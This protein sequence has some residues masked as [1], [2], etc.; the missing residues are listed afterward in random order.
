MFLPLVSTLA[1]RFGRIP[2]RE[3]QRLLD[4]MQSYMNSLNESAAM[5]MD[6]TPSRE[7]PTSPEDG[8]SKEAIGAISRAYR[9]IFTSRNNSSQERPAKRANIPTNSNTPHFSQDAHF[10]Q[11]SSQPTSTQSYQSCPVAPAAQCP[12]SHNN[13]QHTFQNVDNNR[14]TYT[15]TTHQNHDQENSTAPHRGSSANLNSYRNA[16][17]SQNQPSCPWKFAPGAKVLVGAGNILRY[18]SSPLI[19]VISTVT[20]DPFFFCHFFSLAGL[21]S[22]CMACIRSRALQSGDMGIFLSVF[23]SCCEG[24]GRIC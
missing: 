7:T 8:N 11:A 22:Q 14:Y 13:N 6:S 23:H 10:T 15:V 2:K 5:E 20:N 18:I 17:S 12:V 21:S 3:K 9:D 1:V 19:H 4:E 16:G 24:G